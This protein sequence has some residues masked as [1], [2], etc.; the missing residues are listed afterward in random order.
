M[1]IRG[2]RESFPRT[3]GGD[4]IMAGL[5]LTGTAL[6]APLHEL[7][8]RTQS[9]ALNRSQFTET[10]RSLGGLYPINAEHP[11]TSPYLTLLFRCDLV[12]Y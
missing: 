5:E 1:A 12:H 8:Y 2:L 9:K 6:M 11:A 7:T 3:T 10:G 4:V